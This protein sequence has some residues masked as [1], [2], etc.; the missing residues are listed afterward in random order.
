MEKYF[1]YFILLVVIGLVLG[2]FIAQNSPKPQL[3]VYENSKIRTSISQINSTLPR[4]IGTIG[5]L[6]S[7]IY[8]NKTIIY[9]ISVVGD[10]GI[11]DVYRRNYN[12]FKDILK[13]STIIA[14]G[15][16]NMGDIFA[17][18]LDQ[19]GLY[20]EYRIYTRDGDVT[21]WRMSGHELKDFVDNC[22]EN[23]T[24]ALKKTI[25]IQIEISNLSLPIT[26]E[27]IQN[28][29][30]TVALNSLLNGI[31]ASCLPLGI[32]QIKDDIMFK[33]DVDENIIDLDELESMSE[34]TEDLDIFASSLTEDADLQEFINLIVI[35]HSNLVITYIGRNTNKIVSVKLPYSLLKKHS[36][37]PHYILS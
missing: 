24:T 2:I 10:A 27:D 21:A 28:P 22:K 37:I 18:I 20:V 31:D 32:S 13:Y 12:D 25:E 6:D 35:S 30:K 14:N 29:I 19:K 36:K 9:S 23:P 7:V 4:K 11:K 15:H 8:R 34:K 33:Y 3:T 16:G 26:V 1:K 17:F 5:S